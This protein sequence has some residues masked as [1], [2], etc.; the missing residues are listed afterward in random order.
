MPP[1]R[2]HRPRKAIRTLPDHAV[3][4]PPLLPGEEVDVRHAGAA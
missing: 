2:E 4:T 1:L 3:P